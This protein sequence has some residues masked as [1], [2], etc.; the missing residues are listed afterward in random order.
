MT[1]LRTFRRLALWF[2][3]EPRPLVRFWSAFAVL[4]PLALLIWWVA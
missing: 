3:N 1:T 2:W 4:L